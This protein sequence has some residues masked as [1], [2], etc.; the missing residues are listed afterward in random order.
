MRLGRR[1]ESPATNLEKLH[2]SV[3]KGSREI[4]LHAVVAS[5]DRGYGSL[6]LLKRLLARGTGGVMIMP[7]H[8]FLCHSFVAR[9]CFSLN[10]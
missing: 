2:D 5:T 3:N 10:E 4:S 1:G 9:S 6:K 7:E 8:V